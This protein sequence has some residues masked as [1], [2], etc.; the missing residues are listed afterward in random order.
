MTRTR[1]EFPPYARKDRTRA[2]PGFDPS[3]CKSAPLLKQQSRRRLPTPD[4]FAFVPIR[5]VFLDGIRW[6]VETGQ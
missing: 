5:A 3:D 6:A 1:P 2:G 4:G